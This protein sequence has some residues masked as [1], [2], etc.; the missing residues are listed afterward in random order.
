ML[1]LQQDV[2]RPLVGLGPR[3]RFK[4]RPTTGRL[5]VGL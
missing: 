3:G 2:H 5:V 4:D 1:G